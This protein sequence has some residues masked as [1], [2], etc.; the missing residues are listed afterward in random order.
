LTAA[1]NKKT[2]APAKRPKRRYRLEMTSWSLFAWLS[3]LFLLMSWIFVLGILVGRGLIPESVTPLAELRNQLNKFQER[4]SRGQKVDQGAQKEQDYDSNL[5]FYTELS[6]RKGDEKKRKLLEAKPEHL[7]TG[8]D[9]RKQAVNQQPSPESRPEASTKEGVAKAKAE[10][11]K[12]LP[13]GSLKES[14]E[15]VAEKRAI[16]LS[17]SGYTVQLASLGDGIKA[18]Q[19]VERLI[20]GGYDAYY[21][22]VQVR[23][24]T[25]YRIRCGKF[26]TRGE[27][28]DYAKRLAGGTGLKGVVMKLE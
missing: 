22:K 27:G 10:T 9:E 25:W 20:K 21:E 28:E 3:C 12:A 16:P 11:S 8:S 15:K 26:A 4:V 1:V 6:S 14:A 24:K 7:T 13:D 19:T 23:G 17:K 5:A 2:I 18:Q